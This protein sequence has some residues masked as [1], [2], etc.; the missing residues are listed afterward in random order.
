MQSNP[1]NGGLTSKFGTPSTAHGT[2]RCEVIVSMAIEY[3]ERTD[4]LTIKRTHCLLI[5]TSRYL[6]VCWD[7]RNWNVRITCLKFHTAAQDETKQFACQLLF[8]CLVPFQDQQKLCNVMYWNPQAYLLFDVHGWR[9][10]KV[11]RYH[12]E[13]G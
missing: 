9:N 4:P 6:R 11:Y 12:D 3:H 7:G 13:R 5:L 8:I 2:K 1:S 10:L